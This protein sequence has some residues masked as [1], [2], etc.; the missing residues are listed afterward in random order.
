VGAG[1]GE[2]QPAPA[3]ASLPPQCRGSGKA[4]VRSIAGQRLIVRT[5][6]APDG[7][8]LDRARAGEIA[9]VI[10]FPGLS[11]DEAD[12]KAGVKELQAAAAKG[13]Q[14]PLIV[15]TDQEG[16]EVKRFALA[17]PQ[18]SPFQLADLGDAGDAR[19]EGKATGA[20]L[21]GVGINTDLAP[22]LDV[23][24]VPGS[25]IQYRAFG[26]DPRQVSELGLAFAAGL[27][28]NGVL[29]TAKHFPGLGRST[30]NTDYAPSEVNASRRV[31]MRDL[32]PFRGAIAQGIPLVMVGLA[33]YPALGGSEP[34]ALDP[35]IAEDLLRGRLRFKGVTITDDL[36]AGAVAATYDSSDAAVAAAEAGNDLLLF[37][38]DSAPDAL[39]ALEK[40]ITKARI[41][42]AAARRSCVRVVALRE[43][44][45]S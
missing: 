31:L 21:D 35:R 16:G 22:V 2:E 5:D 26:S 7:K 45:E 34:A 17:P 30:L 15:A 13:H 9:G 41:D 44:L 3:E 36:Q 28:K 4:A 43:S 18:R 42:I 23:N 24:A 33:S 27:A 25:I 37:A 39:G 1:A 20:F 38:Q 8:L 11:Q 14:P 10:V 32:E 6:A 12:V 19:L 29:A 40:A